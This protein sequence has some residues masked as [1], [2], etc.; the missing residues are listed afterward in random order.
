MDKSG[1]RR[2]AGVI[3]SIQGSGVGVRHEGKVLY[4]TPVQDFAIDGVSTLLEG[5]KVHGSGV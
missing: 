5:R 3:F 4:R 1:L 2:V